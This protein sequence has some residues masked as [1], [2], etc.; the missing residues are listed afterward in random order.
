MSKV[1]ER[2]YQYQNQ[3]TYSRFFSPYSPYPKLKWLFK[4][5]ISKNLNQYIFS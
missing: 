1:V 5:I 3:L 2:P 4:E